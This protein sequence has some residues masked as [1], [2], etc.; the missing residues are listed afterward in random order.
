MHEIF[1]EQ[2][3]FVGNL[4]YQNAYYAHNQQQTAQAFSEK[5][6]SYSKNVHEEEQQKLW[7]FSKQWYLKLYGFKDEE[8]LA[9]FLSKQKI[10]F[11]AGCGL[12]YIAEWFAQLAPH[13]T[14]IAMDISDAVLVAAEKYA[15]IKNT[16]F[17]KGDITQTPFKDNSIDYV[18]CHAVIMHTENPELTFSELS[19]ILKPSSSA[20]VGAELNTLCPYKG[21]A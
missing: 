9:N 13:S 11:D 2:L 18:S 16:Y 5:W 8:H 12:G 1:K 19:R 17:I 10:I 21:A 4:A 6:T 3:E 7:D 20:V 14:I 15:H